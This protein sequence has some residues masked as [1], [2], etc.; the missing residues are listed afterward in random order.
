MAKRYRDK[1]WDTLP[2][3]ER[4]HWSSDIIKME[5]LSGGFCQVVCLPCDVFLYKRTKHE[6]W[7]HIVS[8]KEQRHLNSR[9]HRQAILLRKLASG[10]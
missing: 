5:L 3:S 9:A 6:K 7:K 4:Q 10:C 1:T 8:V 2:I